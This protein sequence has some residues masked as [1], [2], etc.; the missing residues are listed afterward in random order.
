MDGEK[1]RAEE[2]THAKGPAC[3]AGCSYCCHVHVDVTLPEL[4]AIARHLERTLSVAELAAQVRKL[5]AQAEAVEGLSD[6]ARWAARIPCALLDDRGLCSVHAVRPLRCRAFHSLDAEA[7]RA[8]FDGDASAE[9][10]T[11]PTVARTLDAV[12]D[13][14]DGALGPSH[15]RLERGLLRVLTRRRTSSSRP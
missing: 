13:G 4:V 14:I 2:R 10:A 12:M 8:A 1:A 7:C 9:P 6:E 3:S 11:N 5:S 15:E